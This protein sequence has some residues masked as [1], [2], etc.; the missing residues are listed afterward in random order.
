MKQV[1]LF[2]PSNIAY[3]TPV[4]AIYGQILLSSVKVKVLVIPEQHERTVS[5][6][7]E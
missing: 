2:T 6:S 4:A 5:I 7:Q 3:I 1:F